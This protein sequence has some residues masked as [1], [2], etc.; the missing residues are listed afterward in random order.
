MGTVSN[1]RISYTMSEEQLTQVKAAFATINNF[2]AF[3]IGITPEER[4]ALPKMSSGNKPFVQDAFLAIKN[5][6]ELFPSY[7]KEEEIRKDIVLFDQLAEIFSF[8]AQLNEKI[9][10]TQI[11]AGSEAYV[12]ALSIYR[13]MEAA[14][15]AGVPGTDTIYDQLASRFAN[16]GPSGSTNATP[17]A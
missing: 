6:P 13:L 8:S 15:K 7:M 9:K 5:N 10:D 17:E 3:L 1:N 11:V 2:M 16:N 4:T 14:A 12:S